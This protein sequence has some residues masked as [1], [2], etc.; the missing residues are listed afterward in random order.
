[1]GGPMAKFFA[2]F[3]LA[4]VLRFVTG[5]FVEGGW[6]GEPEMSPW[7]RAPYSFAL[8]LF[9]A[10]LT[11][12]AVNRISPRRLLDS[13]VRR[14]FSQW[15]MGLG[16]GLVGAVLTLLVAHISDDLYVKAGLTGMLAAAATLVVTIFLPRSRPYAC[17]H[18]GSV[19]PARDDTCPGCGAADCRGRVFHGKS[20][21]A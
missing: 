9:L 14:P 17:V 1:M 4:F 10:A 18:C 5:L 6:I 3:S 16:A 12:F 20:A 13:R 19:V 11:L 2:A 8:P 7:Q 15:M 21:A